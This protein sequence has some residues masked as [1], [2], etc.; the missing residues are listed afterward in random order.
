MREQRDCERAKPTFV[1]APVPRKSDIS[2][3]NDI[4]PA[5]SSHGENTAYRK[6]PLSVPR[7][8]EAPERRSVPVQDK[9]S[10]SSDEEDERQGDEALVSSNLQNPSD[11][12][13]LLANASS[14][15]YHSLNSAYPAKARDAGPAGNNVST[16]TSWGP[17]QQGLLTVQDA[18]AL[19]SL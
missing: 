10:G 15:P 13:R 17:I 1:R 8:E 11:A 3:G 12:L 9:D 6:R 14:L 16:W 18:R 19:F 5:T 2:P 4:V 7:F